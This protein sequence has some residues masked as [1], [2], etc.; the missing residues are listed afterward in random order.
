VEKFKSRL[1]NLSMFWAPTHSFAQLFWHY[2]MH[3][4]SYHHTCNT[5]VY[6]LLYRCISRQN[7]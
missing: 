1:F 6:A 7:V 5:N 3:L 2:L 4:F